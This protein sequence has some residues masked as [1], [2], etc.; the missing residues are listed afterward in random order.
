MTPVFSKCYVPAAV[1]DWLVQA[2]Y[3]HGGSQIFLLC[4]LVCAIAILELHD[5]LVSPAAGGGLAVSAVFSYACTIYLIYAAIFVAYP[6][7]VRKVYVEVYFAL[8]S[9]STW[10]PRGGE[11]WLA[12]GWR[13]HTGVMVPLY[14]GVSVVSVIFSVDEWYESWS[15]PWQRLADCTSVAN[16]LFIMF[17]AAAEHTAIILAE[18]RYLS[19]REGGHVDLFDDANVANRIS[20]QDHWWRLILT[21]FVQIIGSFHVGWGEVNEPPANGNKI[22]ALFFV[23]CAIAEA[24]APLGA[25]ASGVVQQLHA[26]SAGL[27]ERWLCFCER[28]ILPAQGD[29]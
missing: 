18:R 3:V 11:G 28:A 15:S 19:D 6:T 22:A 7:Y 4:F 17:T 2:I 24:A 21:R 10:T 16:Q 14:L 20:A 1:V 5:A 9:D 25:Q 12:Y 27:W 26:K 23:G 8:R 13:Q 29:M